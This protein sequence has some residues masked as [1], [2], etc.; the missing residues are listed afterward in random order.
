MKKLLILCSI[1][2]LSIGGLMAK[3]IKELVVTTNPPMSCQ[4]CENKIKKN[5]R[6][7]KGIKN[8]ETNLKDQRVIIDYDADQ[9]DPAKIVKA[10]EKINYKVEVISNNEENKPS[11]EKKPSGS[12]DD[13]ACNGSCCNKK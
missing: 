4:N 6:F 1:L 7:E 12:T 8:I 3:D 2:A 10:F 13:N 9:T 11:K 5:I